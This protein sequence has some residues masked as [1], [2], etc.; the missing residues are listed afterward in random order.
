MKMEFERRDLYGNYPIMPLLAQKLIVNKALEDFHLPNLE[1]GN[2]RREVVRRIERGDK[3]NVTVFTATDTV[4]VSMEADP[5]ANGFSFKA[6]DGSV[7]ESRE[8]IDA[9]W[10]QTQKSSS[11]KSLDDSKEDEGNQKKGRS[12]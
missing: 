11:R 7:V 8:L 9:K 2:I 12:K 4:K 6:N 5:Q 3:L 1:Y 10:I